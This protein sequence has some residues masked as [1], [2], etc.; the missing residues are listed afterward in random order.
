M[1][2]QCGMSPFTGA[3]FRMRLARTRQCT[4]TMSRL[5]PCKESCL[6][7]YTCRPTSSE[8]FLGSYPIHVVATRGM[9]LGTS[10]S[11]LIPF[12]GIHSVGGLTECHLVPQPCAG[13][14]S[15]QATHDAVKKLGESNE[16]ALWG[17]APDD[18]YELYMEM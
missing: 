3:L 10:W 4:G 8:A 9:D 5:I 15:G 13:Q 14:I 2:N 17:Q 18:I 16:I 6:D 12:H 11:I 7:Q 1:P